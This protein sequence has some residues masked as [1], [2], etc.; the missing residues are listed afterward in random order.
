MICNYGQSQITAETKTLSYQANDCRLVI[1]TTGERSVLLK[2]ISSGVT[3]TVN[4][5]QTAYI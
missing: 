3:T 5:C 2:D 4:R 1:Q